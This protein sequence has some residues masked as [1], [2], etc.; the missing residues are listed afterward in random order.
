[1]PELNDL[2]GSF[3]DQEI[4]LGEEVEV[5][6]PYCEFLTGSSG[7]GKT[8]EIKRRVELDHS[9][10]TVGSTTGVSAVNLN[11]RTIHSILGY[12]NTASLEDNFR[13]GYLQARLR[14]L[15]MEDGYRNIV[16]DEV[17][18][19]PSAQLTV[20]YE[21]VKEVNAYKT[22]QAEGRQ[23][24]IVLTGDFMQLPAVSEDGS[25]T[26]DYA[27]LSQYWPSFQANT[28][29]LTKIWR[30]DNLEFVN[31]LNLLRAGKGAEA[32]DLLRTMTR[33]QPNVDPRFDG[34]T[35]LS[36]N[37]EV[38]R[39]NTLRLIQVKGRP[40]VVSSR[41][42]G[43]P[44]GEWKLIPDQ[45]QLKIGALVMILANARSGATGQFEYVNG[46]LGHIVDFTGDDVNRQTFQVKLLRNERIVNIGKI[47]RTTT[48][49]DEPEEVRLGKIRVEDIP[50]C[51]PPVEPPP[52][53]QISLELERGTYHV[54]GIEYFPLRIGFAATVFKVQGLTLDKVQIDY[55]GAWFGHPG[56]LY[57]ALSRCK[58]PE[59]L[60]LVG[61]PDVFVKR[62]KTD[63][64]VL[65]WL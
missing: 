61:L 65:P 56:S 41:R 17:S 13:M 53:G 10:G 58:T 48:T 1:M 36:T 34:T 20:I 26:C 8:F 38:E 40:V 25:K 52:F 3:I 43:K 28:T 27:F 42:W 12:F 47:H 16:I 62:C 50:T 30:Q 54:G 15:A 46:D 2:D 49:K 11:T 45:L 21:A 14:K 23:L 57:V 7:S 31:A 35:I 37:K 39:A 6:E 9:Y 18:M 64:Q 33:F 32:A 29:R 22:M 5:R 44:S 63:P 24:G 19:L 51:A 59:G 60:R 4:D 55:R